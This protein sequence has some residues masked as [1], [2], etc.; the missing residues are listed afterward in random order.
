LPHGGAVAAF[1]YT[2]G[3]VPDSSH[4]VI[5]PA[6][7]ALIVGGAAHERSELTADLWP[8]P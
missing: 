6:K 8:A 2:S 7:R 3:P 5:A 4:E 1:G